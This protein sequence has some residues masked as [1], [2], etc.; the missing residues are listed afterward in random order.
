MLP[1]KLGCS[2]WPFPHRRPDHLEMADPLEETKKLVTNELKSIQAK[3]TTAFKLFKRPPG[4]AFPIKFSLDFDLSAKVDLDPIRVLFTIPSNYPQAFGVDFSMCNDIPAPT[5]RALE[6]GL[7]ERIQALHL[8]CLSFA[9]A[10]SIWCIL[11]LTGAAVEAIANWLSNQANVLKLLAPHLESYTATGADCSTS[12]RFTLRPLPEESSIIKPDPVRLPPPPPPPP[13]PPSPPVPSPPPSLASSTPAKA[14]STG[15]AKKGRKKPKKK[16]DGDDDG[17]LPPSDSE[18]DEEEAARL[19]EEEAARQAF[20]A[21]RAMS[22]TAAPTLGGGGGS[23]G[24]Q[25]AAPAVTAGATRRERKKKM[26]DEGRPGRFPLSLGEGTFCDTQQ[27]VFHLQLS[28]LVLVPHP[29]SSRLPFL[30]LREGNDAVQDRGDH[31]SLFPPVA[32]CSARQ[33]PARR[34]LRAA[35]RRPAPTT[36]CRPRCDRVQGRCTRTRSRVTSRSTR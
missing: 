21:A 28:R 18:P 26:E 12:V 36:A 29:P 3:F 19:R 31:C 14:A 11:R 8:T 7:V 24:D 16:R 35:R 25:A 10:L 13:P 22:S 34:P 27:Y 23:S 5:Q 33:S 20:R 1:D 32:H 2:P 4:V 9:I 17:L 30:V 15:G 6:A